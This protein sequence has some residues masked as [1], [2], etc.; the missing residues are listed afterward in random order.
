MFFL[1]K[2]INKLKISKIKHPK[3][4]RFFQ[5]IDRHIIFLKDRYE[6][7]KYRHGN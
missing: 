1:L 3:A 7:K 6:Y 4:K 2:Q 5:Y